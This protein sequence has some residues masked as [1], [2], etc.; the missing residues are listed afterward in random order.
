MWIECICH[1]L[2]FVLCE[3]VCVCVCVSE[4]KV[5][6]I[7]SMEM[8]ARTPKPFFFAFYTH[9]FFSIDSFHF[10]FFFFVFE[11]ETRCKWAYFINDTVPLSEERETYFFH[12][13][14][15]VLYACL[16]SFSF[17]W[18]IVFVTFNSYKYGYLQ[19][20]WVVDA[21]GAG[22]FFFCRFLYVDVSI[23]AA[24]FS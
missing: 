13:I 7:D 21:P 9:S 22:V 11:Q 4:L 1:W 3:C 19:A 24:N 17:S 12:R 2:R 18:S 5:W 14:C 16:H 20:G 6:Y 15:N 23:D 8:N 10:I